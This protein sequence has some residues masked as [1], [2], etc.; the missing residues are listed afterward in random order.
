MYFSVYAKTTVKMRRWEYAV[1]RTAHG[2]IRARPNDWMGITLLGS[3]NFL[4]DSF[5]KLYFCHNRDEH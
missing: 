3:S 4:I 2:N 5:P 1:S